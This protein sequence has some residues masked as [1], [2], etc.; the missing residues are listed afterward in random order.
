MWSIPAATHGKR[1]VPSTHPCS[2]PRGVGVPGGPGMRGSFPCPQA[3]QSPNCSSCRG[4][5]HLPFPHKPKFPL[6]TSASSRSPC[7]RDWQRAW[8]SLGHFL[9][10]VEGSQCVMCPCYPAGKGARLLPK[11]SP[12]TLLLRAEEASQHFPGQ[13]LPCSSLP[14]LGSSLPGQGSPPPTRASEDAAMGG[15]MFPKPRCKQAASAPGTGL[16]SLPVSPQPGRERWQSPAW[17]RCGSGDPQWG[18]ST[19]LASPGLRRFLHCL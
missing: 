1:Q 2:A 19:S 15:R 17:H 18:H 9:G 14:G 5:A 11:P 8:P 12:H 3:S 4:P 7:L 13:S 10:V 16:P 6:Q